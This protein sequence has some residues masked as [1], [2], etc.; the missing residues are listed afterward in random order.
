MIKVPSCVDSDGGE[1]SKAECSDRCTSAGRLS[2]GL[3]GRGKRMGRGDCEVVKMTSDGG[4]ADEEDMASGRM[5]VSSR[6][7][8]DKDY[9]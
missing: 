7:V 1:A 9:C 3:C 4:V 8:A 2:V 6:K 5:V